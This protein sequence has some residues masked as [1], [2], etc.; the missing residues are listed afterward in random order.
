MKDSLTNHVF[1]STYFTDP[2]YH[3]VASIKKALRAN[4]IEYS[5]IKRTK[6][7]CER[8]YM[9]VHIAHKTF[10]CYKYRP[11]YLLSPSDRK[12]F[13]TEKFYDRNSILSTPKNEQCSILNEEDTELRDCDLILDGGNIVLCG[14]RLILT[15]KVLTENDSKTKEQIVDELKRAFM[16]EHVILIPSDPYEIEECSKYNELPLCHA[17]GVL[18][19]IDDNSILI[20][21][22]GEDH[23]GYC[24]KLKEILSEYFDESNIHELRFGD[25]R[26]E[27]SWIYINFLRIGDI[28]LMPTVG[29]I[30]SPGDADSICDKMAA[31]QLKE[32]LNVK[33]VIPINTRYLTFDN[34]DNN[35]GALHCVSWN[36]YL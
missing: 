25:N 30:N 6:D 19:P 32:K 11:D 31:E 34:P 5:N 29:D 21:D 2:E 35:G 23:K 3:C 1:F 28:V 10:V 4:G 36:I 16:V 26:T 24:T 15:D 12:Q 7:I 18:A 17:D 33:K 8:D 27:N 9:P 13:I 22:Y 14:N 20:S